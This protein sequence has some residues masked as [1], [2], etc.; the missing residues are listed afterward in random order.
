MDGKTVTAVSTS[1]LERQAG[2]TAVR[3]DFQQLVREGVQT[4]GSETM[5]AIKDRIRQGILQQEEPEGTNGHAW[6][7]K[8]SNR[9]FEDFELRKW[10]GFD[11]VGQWPPACP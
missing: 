5:E 3:S 8:T 7:G 4:A 1:L 10:R 6:T 9:H 2:T 11:F